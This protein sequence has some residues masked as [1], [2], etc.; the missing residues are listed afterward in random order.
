MRFFNLL[1]FLTLLTTYFTNCKESPL[2]NNGASFFGIYDR[3]D[4]TWA[5]VYTGKI[6][7]K[8]CGEI[9]M[10]LKISSDFQAYELS[11]EYTGSRQQKQTIRTGKLNTERGYGKDRNATLF[12][13]DYD[14]P[15]SEQ[16][17]FVRLTKKPEEVIMLSKARKNLQKEG[18]NY[19][20]KKVAG[21][22]KS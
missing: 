13:T 18:R 1:L 8:D 22:R 21:K 15:A 20:L 6:Y 16:K 3:R 10:T 19:T 7:C 14:K 17:Y 2:Q 5:D 9:A 4:S 12:I 11:E